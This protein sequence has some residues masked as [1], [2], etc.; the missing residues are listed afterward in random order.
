MTDWKFDEK[1]EILHLLI[2]VHTSSILNQHSYE[3]D[4]ALFV[5]G[6]SEEMY[7]TRNET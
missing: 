5:D 7:S 3:Y 2:R 6:K 4:I 1:F